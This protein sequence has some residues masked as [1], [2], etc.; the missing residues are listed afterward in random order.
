MGEKADRGLLEAM[1]RRA[2]ATAGDFD[3]PQD[4]AN[5]LWALA[6]MGKGVGGFLVNLID[7]LAARAIDFRDQ[8]TSETKD[9]LH[10]WLLACDLD[11]VPLPQHP[12]P[13]TPHPTPYNL[14][15]TPH[16]PHPEL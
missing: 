9:L 8:L 12:T 14:Q 10:P 15:P 16:T 3:K 4:V 1:Q 5:V 11:R 7:T 2:T 13:Y 6:A